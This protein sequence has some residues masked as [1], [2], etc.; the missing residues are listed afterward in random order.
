MTRYI[1][2]YLNTNKNRRKTE[3]ESIAGFIT[4]DMNRISKESK[5]T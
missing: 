4:F 3:R 1:S 5:K 2:A